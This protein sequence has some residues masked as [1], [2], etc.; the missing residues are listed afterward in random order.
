[1]AAHT[2]LVI[3]GA[4]LLCVS[5]DQMLSRSERNPSWADL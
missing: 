3:V 4:R 1:M 5:R 2:V